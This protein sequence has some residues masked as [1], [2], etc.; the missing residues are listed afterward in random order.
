[1]STIIGLAAVARSGKDTVASMLLEHPEVAAYALAD[2]LKLGCQALFGLTDDEAWLDEIKETSIDLWGVSPRQ[3]FQRAGTEWMRHDNPDH[4][5]LRADK[6]L[7][8]AALPPSAPTPANLASPSSSI[9]L[10]VQAFWGMSDEQTWCETLRSEKDDFWGRT[11]Q[12]MFSVLE[13][14]VQRDFPEYQAR[15]A[16]RPVHAPTRKL[17]DSSGKSIFIIK[18]IRYENEASFW[19]SHGGVIWH[20]T[21]NNATKVN[22]HSS[23]DGILILGV[24]FHIENNGTLEELRHKVQHA[25]KSVTSL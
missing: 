5:L 4:W 25:W 23:E 9:W 13:S 22:S 15:R 8:H 16:H 1:M 2:P 3:M 7:N 10:A 20:I 18:D 21:R 19:R 6:Q 24:D 14:Y 12:E 17:T 11:P